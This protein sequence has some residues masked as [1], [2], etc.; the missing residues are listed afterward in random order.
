MS[1][2]TPGTPTTSGTFRALAA[3]ASLAALTAC[4][5]MSTAIEAT[6]G[7]SAAIAVARFDVQNSA[8]LSGG[9]ENQPIRTVITDNATWTSFW[10]TI[11][12]GVAVPSGPVPTVDFA[13]EMV[14]VAMTAVRPT[15]GYSVRIDGV[16]EYTDYIAAD[17][18][19]GSPSPSCG[20][21]QVLTRPLDMV[22]VPRRDK[23]VRFAVRSTVNACGAVRSD[24]VAVGYGKTVSVGTVRVTLRRVESDSRC[25]LNA[26]CIWEGDAAVALR[27]ESGGTTSD[28]TLH[29]HPRG[30][31][32]SAVVGG[33]EF[34]LVGL[35][36]Y[37]SGQGAPVESAY[38]A[39]LTVR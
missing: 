31:V 8:Q 35:T 11:S 6:T 12:G 10:A 9:G 19:E 34:R 24:S 20:T 13:N 39:R 18:V 16:R 15:G 5:S 7:A 14:I 2:H 25:P 1:Y 28:V 29:T 4:S 38:T 22:Q 33:R 37:P 32:V 23:P 36:P 21:A 27:F 3:V 26:M 30:G 17:V